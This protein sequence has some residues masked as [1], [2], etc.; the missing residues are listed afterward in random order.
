MKK[1]RILY[2]ITLRITEF[3][4]RRFILKSFFS[5]YSYGIIKMFVNQFA[6]SIFGAVLA[7][8]TATAGNNTL[9]LVVSCFAILFYLFLIYNMVWEIGAKDKISVDVGKKEYRPHTGLWMAVVANIPNYIIAIMYIIAYPS[10]STAT[11]A[12][13]LAAVAKFA[14]VILQGMYLGTT[15][16]IYVGGVQM[17]QLWWTYIIIIIPS[18]LTAWLA[19]FLGHKNFTV[20][21][22]FSRKKDD[23]ISK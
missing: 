19:Y 22:L 21:S 12:G 17:N 8:A 10:M 23:N 20:V 15:S 3:F 6:I 18:L 1:E 11:W 7:M 13:N 9:T 4:R 14:S 5:K 16:T 2:I